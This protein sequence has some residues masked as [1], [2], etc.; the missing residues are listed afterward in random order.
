MK[1][2]KIIHIDADC[3]YASVEVRDDPSLAGRPIAVGGR[4][5]RRGVIATA[6]YEARQFG[7]RSAMAASRA[8]SLCPQLLILQT[9][10]QLYRE[11]SGQFHQVFREY[12]DM[13]EPLSLDEAFLDV[14]DCEQCRGSAT[15]IAAEIRARI[16][17]TTGL[18]VSAGVA[19]NKFLAKVA[20][21]WEKPDGLFTI[22]PDQVADFVYELPVRRI[23]GVGKVTGEKLHRMGAKTCGDLQQIPLDT[24]VRR[25]GKYGK[26]LY[27]V[28]RGE[29]RR[30]VKNT[31]QRKSISVER[32]YA[33]DIEQLPDM[34]AQLET[35]LEE[36]DRRFAKI[37]EKYTPT[38]RFVKI[39]YRDFTQ[40]TLEE[41]FGENG[42]P[43]YL[44]QEYQ[45]L[46]SAAWARKSQPVR[47]LGVG[48]RLRPIGLE[49]EDQLKLFP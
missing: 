37:A 27:D 42:E 35:L 45:R 3:F 23:N 13:V 17:E 33:E 26:R 39:K 24:L 34:L 46:L 12:T 22:A 14:S 18:T 19:P 8:M 6:S 5:D 4:P 48:L 1:T 36:L 7:V 31:R 11:I 43:W 38:K 28:A 29:D 20:S 25:F 47:L 15:L 2:R 10:M 40:T 49:E 30:Q 32:T 21:D 41:T 16:R 9:R 44:A